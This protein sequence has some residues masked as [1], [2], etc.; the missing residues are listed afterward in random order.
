MRVFLHRLLDVLLRGRRE[1]RLD[2]EI[3]THLAWL[4]DDFE[5]RG[6]TPG[7]AHDAARRA[8]GGVDQVKARHRQQRGLPA[9][10][11][12]SQ[13]VRFALRLFS[14]DRSFAL[15]AVLVLG[16]GIGI[17][18]LF[19]TL[20][21][22]HVLRGLPIAD[23][24]RLVDLSMVD[25]RGTVRALSAPEV[26]DLRLASTGLS[27]LAAFTGAPVALGDESRVPERRDATYLSGNALPLLGIRPLR[28]RTVTTEDD[29][30]GAAPVVML[31]ERVW[32]SRYG[33]DPGIIGREVLVNGV[34]A[35]VIGVLSDRS[36][37]PSAADVWLPLA[38]A[39]GI[40]SQRRDV[41]TLRAVGRL[42][43]GV[44]IDD[45][46]AAIQTAVDR[47]ALDH[48]DTNRNLRA[49]VISI[50]ERYFGRLA[51]PWLAFLSAGLVAV[52]IASANVA[53]LVLAHGVRRSREIA[54]R[55]SLGASRRRV[56]RQLL[57]EGAVLATLGA[58]LGLALATVG[59]RLAKGLVPEGV[60]P[61]WIDY[62]TSPRLIVALMGVS[63]ASVLVFGL[64]PAIGASRVDVN[65]VL[66]DGG[67]TGTGS[68]ASRRLAGAFLTAQLALGVVLFAQLT[69]GMRVFRTAT[70]TD[71]ALE[72]PGIFTASIALPPEKY[73]TP[74]ERAEFYR[75]LDE[76]IGGL[77]GVN[78]Y[79]VTEQLPMLGV[80][81]RAVDIE[82]RN[83]GAGEAAQ[84]LA[85]VAIGP[86][87]FETLR[88]PLIKGRELADADAASGASNAIVNERFVELFFADRDPIGQRIGLSP[89]TGAAHPPAW[90]TIVGVA[91][92]IRQRPLPDVE[93]IVYTPLA[94][95]APATA[96]LIVRSGVETEAMIDALRREVQALD[97][98]LPLYR[99]LTLARVVWDAQ[100]NGRMSA[101]LATAV[102]VISLMLAAFG[103]YAVTAH[104]V[105]LRSREMAVRMALGAR[106]AQVVRSALAGVAV[107]LVVGLGLGLV[108][109][110]AWSRAFA[111][112][113][114]RVSVTDPAHLVVVTLVLAFIAAMACFVP[115]RRATRVDPVAALRDD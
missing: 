113:S 36:G 85:T 2:D 1:R 28:G 91:Q 5:R 12:L 112:E 73:R 51:G 86:R 87:Y 80:A 42:R 99:T 60:L 7:E 19:F 68:R 32:Q 41:R 81:Q 14:R 50:D 6:L 75:R 79:T 3:D 98:N 29:R 93:P 66:K 103:L 26:D 114:A 48:S 39:P 96:G 115:V 65:R 110:V 10:D 16:L 108:G 13:D 105:S 31:T 76:R 27:G 62:S 11:A 25:E 18:H 104:G 47:F 4:A 89:P 52:V 55:T 24:D 40:A 9:L 67:R 71:G 8:F 23:A 63:A 37:F 15:T 59:I 54:I 84:A 22:A 107:P 45:A 72:N 33:G 90:F 58:L 111:T 61:Y 57:I 20:V 82:G 97:A 43:D 77:P 46:R 94:A 78:A 74:A 64:L 30:P 49:R 92:S 95:A 70:P 69:A 56:F 21:H 44:T 101:F 102:I 106:T 34:P 38:Y 35:S 109:I 83:R 53:N 100:W 17:N 88:V